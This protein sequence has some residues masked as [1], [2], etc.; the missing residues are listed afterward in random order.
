MPYVVMGE[1]ECGTEFRPSNKTHKTVSAAHDELAECM[2]RYVEA[3]R[4]WVERLVDHRAIL[5]SG[6]DYE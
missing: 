6:D 3:R 5:W 2:E 1:D 4:L